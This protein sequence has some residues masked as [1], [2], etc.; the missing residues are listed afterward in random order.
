[1][2][3]KVIV[4]I[5]KN[6]NPVIWDYVRNEETE[7]DAENRAFI[8]SMEKMRTYA[9]HHKN[10]PNI[11]ADGSEYWENEYK[12]EEERE[13]KV[14]SYEDFLRIE[15]EYLLSLPLTEITE[16][17]YEEMLNVLPPL[18]WTTIDNIEMFCMSEFY[19]GTYTTQCAHDRNSGK[20]YEKLVDYTDRKTWIS[21]ILKEEQ[22]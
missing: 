14:M 20:Y 16:E 9:S 18:A 8:A 11:Q 3:D 2:M 15:K 5:G 17:R 22:K 6:K 21:E 10:F 7:E 4:A 12:R 13:Y 19:T 1:M